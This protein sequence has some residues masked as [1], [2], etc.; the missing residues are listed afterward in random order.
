MGAHQK[1]LKA[2]GIFYIAVDSDSLAK[3]SS[4]HYELIF[5]FFKERISV[6]LRLV[7][8]VR[9]GRSM[10]SQQVLCHC[11]N[12]LGVIKCASKAGARVPEN[13]LIN[14]LN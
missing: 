7:P 13:K 1:F 11:T 9:R 4:F 3:V 8:S 12:D 14:N 2:H 10:C 5:V 6:R